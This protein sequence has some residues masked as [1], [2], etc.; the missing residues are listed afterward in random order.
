MEN[1]SDLFLSKSVKRL[2]NSNQF[3]DDHKHPGLL[4]D[5]FSW[6][7]SQENQKKCINKVRGCTGDKELLTNL[8]R[9][10]TAIFNELNIIQLHGQTSG[11]LALHLSR[12][13]AH[14][15]V[16]F[17]LHPT[18]GF[19]YLPAT[20]LKGATRTWAEEVWKSSQNH[21]DQEE[22][23]N[24][25]DTVFGTTLSAG[26]I[27]FHDAW[28]I[29]W[30]SLNCD[31]LNSHH[32]EY[33]RSAGE[34][35]P[36]DTEEPV[37]VYFLSIMAGSKFEFILSDRENDSTEMLELVKSWM[38]NALER[39]GVGA[40]TA[41]GY[42]RISF[43]DNTHYTSSVEIFPSKFMRSEYSLIL[44]SPAFLAGADQRDFDCDLRPASLRGVLRWWWRTM[45]AHHLSSSDLAQL[46]A[47]VW[48]DT[49]KGS[50]V[51]LSILSDRMNVDAISYNKKEI[52]ERHRLPKPKNRK[53]IQGL[54]YISY[55]MD[56][57]KNANGRYFRMPDDKWTLTL[58]TKEVRK[59]NIN[60]PAITIMKQIEASLWLLTH[61]GGI[62]SKSRKGF[63]SFESVRVKGINSIEDCKKISFEF[64]NLCEL[65][66]QD[67]RSRGL[68]TLESLLEPIE[69]ETSVN[70]PWNTLDTIGSVYQKFI[71][72]LPKEQ[73]QDFGLPRKKL[74]MN[75]RFASPVHWSLA[76]KAN[77][78]LVI[79]MVVFAQQSKTTSPFEKSK[80]NFKEF[81][82]TIKTELES[83]NSQPQTNIIP[84]LLPQRQKSQLKS[85][86]E[87]KAILLEKKTKK[88]GWR[89]QELVS[90]ITGNIQNYIEMP[91][92]LKPGDEV[93]LIVKIPN[94]TN[95][96]FAWPT[97][98]N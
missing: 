77:K 53:T 5:K 16:G 66:C 59:D 17:A 9:R 79:R 92:D 81:R 80:S 34:T 78:N 94:P 31:I 8:R 15:N 57:T 6:S 23:Q 1:G 51:S 21:T 42:G 75:K 25:I 52:G 22:T 72:S 64:R 20:S 84:P 44:L 46:E 69:I 48:G 28:P 27:T 47:L 19:A 90:R 86:E 49:N 43:S 85:G 4:L 36:R 62:G 10:R 68:S 60:I 88:G 50:N 76:R 93:T 40:K 18:Y 67:N 96:A 87:V 35:F 2:L 83:L 14:E 11:S 56:D 37:P 73:R 91:A 29:N 3:H 55:G 95:A 65:N 97:P 71:K 39:S 63:G 82:N 12:A 32:T 7:S 70:C 61:F 58:T 45:H 24:K 26:R 30:P 98:K 89:A 33:Y 54:F 38:C 74:S 41:S 13:N